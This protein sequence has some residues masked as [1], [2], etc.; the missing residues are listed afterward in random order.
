MRQGR[1]TPWFYLIPAIII[2]AIFVAYPALR[3]ILFSIQNND[4]SQL[5]NTVCQEGA[6]CWG[7]LENYR[8]ALVSEQ[9]LLALRNT[10]LWLL[11]M[12]PGTAVLGL[13]LAVLTERVRYEALAKS[14]I[15]M[16]MAI[17]FVGAAIIWRFVYNPDPGI[18]ILNAIL[19]VFGAE[20]KAWL[21][22]DPPI[23][24]LLLTIVGIW[25]WTGFTMTLIA[26]ALRN[27]PGEI[28]EAA[29]V[30]GANEFQVFFRI[31]LPQLA[32]TIAVVMTTMTINTLK[33]FDIVWVMKGI[34]TDVIATRMVSEMYL[35][36]NN[37]LSAAYAV[38]LILLIVPVMYY[39]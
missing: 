25:I 21:A 19:G 33:M 32:P 10:A 36:K 26:A 23:N 15:F 27:I 1:W 3:T 9:G 7:V 34:D 37:G 16:P 30:D 28:L 29:R 20:P 38:I 35:S 6:P 5:A 39:N 24:T 17:S 12:V 31:M 13:L 14:L 11:I 8:Q 4:G 18:G 2:L 22:S